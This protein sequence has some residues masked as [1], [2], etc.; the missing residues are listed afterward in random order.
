MLTSFSEKKGMHLVELRYSFYH[1]YMRN[2]IFEIR[3]TYLFKTKAF[4]KFFEIELCANFNWL[5]AEQGI[6]LM[7]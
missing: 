4:V 3:I 7:D 2:S 1:V 5:D 6:S